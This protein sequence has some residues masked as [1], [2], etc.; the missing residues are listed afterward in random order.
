MLMT[1]AE[2]DRMR[3]AWTITLLEATSDTGA[4]ALAR[5]QEQAGDSAYDV[6]PDPFV[7]RREAIQPRDQIGVCPRCGAWFVSSSGLRRYCSHNCAST[8]R[9]RRAKDVA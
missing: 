1:P 6:V 5:R 7:G 8:M 9:Q 3:D 2:I 4:L